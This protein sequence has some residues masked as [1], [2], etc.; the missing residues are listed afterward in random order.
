MCG[1]TSVTLGTTNLQQT[2][3]FMVDILGLTFDKHIDQ[4]MRFGDADLN[5]GTRIHFIEVPGDE[6][7]TSH[8]ES[9]G[10]R[11]PSDLGLTEYQEILDNHG[12]AHTTLK[13][14]NGNQYFSFEDYNNHVISIYSN[15]NNSGVGLG[16]PSINSTV[17]P[18]HQVQGLGPVILK[19]NDV[20][21]TSQILS[22]IF[23][24]ELF[25]EYMPY[26]D[27][28]YYVQ[29][30]NIGT[31]GLGGEIHLCQ[32][33]PTIQL[34]D[35]GVVDQIEF[36]TQDQ[37]QFNEV[38]SKLNQIELPYETLQQD[39]FESIRITENSGLSFIYTLQY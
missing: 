29:V 8:I 24:L 18:L 19:V 2:K 4:G 34:P 23:G 7:E 28:N 13:E 3:H 14:L 22:R 21:T 30:F 16:M 5:P 10:L 37:A 17:N 31:G 38:M 33:N 25:A 26:E 35:Y 32:A 15:E 9:I 39:D 6:L 36:S 12:I 27:A 20:T 1:L 11:T